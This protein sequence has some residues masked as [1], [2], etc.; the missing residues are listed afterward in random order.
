MPWSIFTQGGG[1]GAALTWARDLLRKIGAPLSTGNQQFVYDWETSEGGGGRFNP[2]NQG[3]V[4]G[5]PELTTTG[6]QFGGGAA[7]YASWAAGLTGAADYLAMGNSTAIAD[8]LR[9]GRPQAARAALIASPWAASHYGGGSGFSD[10]PLPGRATALPPAGDAGGGGTAPGLNLNPLD[11]FGIPAVLTAEATALLKEA[12]LV[13]PLIL[14]GA[15]LIVLGLAR[16]TGADK[17]IRAA[18][19]EAAAAAQAGAMP[20]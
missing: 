15:A 9:A 14:G 17:K 20:L 8:N 10:A 4:P 13:G 3:P 18:G 6:S 2:L 19:T 7:D 16:A 12:V 1:Q 11:G 5:H